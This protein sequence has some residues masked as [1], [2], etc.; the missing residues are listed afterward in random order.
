MAR[1]VRPV[2]P[3]AGVQAEYNRRLQRLIDDMVRSVQFWVEGEYSQQEDRIAPELGVDASPAVELQQTIRKLS[4]RWQKNFNEGAE[5][6]ADWFARKSFGS[7]QDQL[8]TILRDAGIS[9]QFNPNREVLDAFAAVRAENVQLIRSISQE[10]LG[11]VEGDVMRSVTTGRDLAQLS[12]DLQKRTGIT[13]RR[14]ALIARDQN[15]K[16]TAAI[17]S[18]R[19][20][21]MGITEGIWQHSHAGKTPR[22][23]HVKAGADKLRFDLRKGAYLD[24]KWVLPGQEI[25]CRCTWRAVIPGLE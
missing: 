6:L 19:Q 16:A 18:I 15:N 4:R 23:S 2:R 10:Y 7:T 12:Q 25:N 9:V 5:K 22:P 24:G 11:D 20:T 14:A 21:Q 3:N 17:N 8:K 1:T 13:K